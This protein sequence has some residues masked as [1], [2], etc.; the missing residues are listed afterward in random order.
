MD[1]RDEENIYEG[2]GDNDGGLLLN[3]EDRS[4]RPIWNDNA[5]GYLRGMRGC[6]LLATKKRERR[7]KRELEKSASQT[8][9]IVEM[10]SVQRNKDL[11]HHKD[12]I[13]GTPPAVSVPETLKRGVDQR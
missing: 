1:N 3:V 4:F 9:S 10:F 7:R 12:P 6:G 13:F 8:R 5:G 2:L 11:S